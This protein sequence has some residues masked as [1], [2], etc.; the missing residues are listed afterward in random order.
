VWEEDREPTIWKKKRKEK[1]GV[2]S[3]DTLEKKRKLD[4]KLKVQLDADEDGHVHF[5]DQSRRGGQ[6]AAW[7]YGPLRRVLRRLR[8]QSLW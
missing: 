4:S 3:R 2:K 5:G 7:S 6:N 1:T 8:R